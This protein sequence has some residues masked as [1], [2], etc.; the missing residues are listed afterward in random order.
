MKI[1]WLGHAAF[2]ITS[3]DGTKILTDPY[4]SGGFSG[5]LRYSPIKEKVDIITTSHSHSDH[6][7]MPLGLTKETQIIRDKINATIKGI[8]I[9]TI[10]SFHD[11]VGGRERGYNSIFLFDVDG[12]KIAHFGDLGHALDDA[13]MKEL[14]QIDVALIPVGGT[15]TVDAKGAS[16]IIKKIKPKIV[17]PMHFK[18][19]KVRLDIDEVDTFLEDK[20]NVERLRVS[21]IEIKPNML[22][23]KETLIIVLKYSH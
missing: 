10:D 8:K 20:E 16:D 17:I 18:T 22:S 3:G 6:C 1:E 9:K 19:P 14:G 7:H 11:L 5:A 15:F 13:K 2:I 12:I 4:E 23:S 21:E